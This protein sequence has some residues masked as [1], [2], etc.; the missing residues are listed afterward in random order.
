MTMDITT[1]YATGSSYGDLDHNDFNQAL[2]YSFVGFGPVA[3]YI[4]WLLSMFM[5][6]PPWM[7][8]MPSETT[9]QYRGLQEVFESLFNSH[10]LLFC[11]EQHCP[12]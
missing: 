8:I 11:P 1:V 6:I 3:K 10:L 12:S 4:P 5:M 9:A 7:M 2:V